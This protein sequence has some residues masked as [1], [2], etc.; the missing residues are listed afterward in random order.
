MVQILVKLV[1]NGHGHL[2]L[3]LD[4]VSEIDF[5]KSSVS[6]KVGSL[7]CGEEMT[8]KL[9]IVEQE[10][11]HVVLHQEPLVKLIQVK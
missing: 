6:H 9:L 2:A 3:V 8:E 11:H 5:Q 10:H 4:I 1:V 7:I